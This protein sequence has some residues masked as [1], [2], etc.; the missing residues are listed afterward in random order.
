[1][2]DLLFI[3]IK[4]IDSLAFANATQKR[5]INISKNLLKSIPAN[6]FAN[7]EFLD[8]VDLSSNQISDMN[9]SVFAGK[10]GLS[11]I[12][13]SNS[14]LKTI[15][16]C[17]ILQPMKNWITFLFHIIESVKLTHTIL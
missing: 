6:A 15:P 12:T 16:L 11:I 2:V 17:F 9:S 7:N 13:I 10:T 1:M 8:D 14:T 3:Q 4:E 5:E